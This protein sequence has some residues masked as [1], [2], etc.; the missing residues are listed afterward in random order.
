[1]ADINKFKTRISQMLIQEVKDGN[2][3][4]SRPGL[5]EEDDDEEDDDGDD[6]EEHA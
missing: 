6:G 2:L 3:F 1:V 5:G 4:R